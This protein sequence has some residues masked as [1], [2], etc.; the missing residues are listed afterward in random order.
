MRYPKNRT[1]HLLDTPYGAMTRYDR[2]TISPSGQA[3]TRE[4]IINDLCAF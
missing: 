1:R 4:N 2:G 3:L